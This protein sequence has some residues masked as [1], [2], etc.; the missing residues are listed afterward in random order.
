MESEMYAR[1]MGAKVY[2]DAGWKV[3]PSTSPELRTRNETAPFPEQIGGLQNVNFG[4]TALVDV[5]VAVDANAQGQLR[6]LDHR[7]GRL[8]INAQSTGR[9]L[10]TFGIRH[11][12]EWRV[13]VDRN[14]QPALRVDGCLLGAI[15]PAGDHEVELRFEPTDFYLGAKLSLAGFGALLAYLLSAV[16]PRPKASD[17]AS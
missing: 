7:P 17:S 13:F 12:H 3:A 15:L 4:R 14:E 8:R 1:I 6:W 9:V 10:A 5:P 2:W 11:Q 16:L